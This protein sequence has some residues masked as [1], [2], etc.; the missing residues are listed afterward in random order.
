MTDDPIVE[1]KPKSFRWTTI[2]TIGL[3]AVLLVLAFRGVAW[4]EFLA[5]LRGGHPGTIV[6]TM[7]ILTV[8]LFIRGIRW[9]VLLSA[10]RRIAPLTMFWATGLGYMGNALLPARA[11]EVMRSMAIGRA[12]QMSRSYVFATAMS[13]RIMD[14]L[15]LVLISLF[16]LSSLEGLPEWLLTASQVFG[17]V[18]VGS[19]AG[20]MLAPRMESF[21]KRLLARLPLPEALGAKIGHVLEQFLLGMRAFQHGGRALGFALLSVVVWLLDAV[22]AMQV[23]QALDLSLNLA[24]ALLLLAA[25]GLS[26]AAPSTPGYVGIYQFVA[27]TVLVP[28]GFS[29]SEALAYIVLF[30]AISYIT[31]VSWG[32]IGMWQLRRGGTRLE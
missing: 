6:L 14:A 31:I 32:F 17:V 24:Q 5:T 1:E 13:E 19:I 16:A 20:L 30:Q 22:I 10:E 28:F 12:A 18:G 9:G 21:F 2:A 3:A 26:S 27:V 29:Q 7:L 15:M 23:A 11:G 8:S 25:L 4:G